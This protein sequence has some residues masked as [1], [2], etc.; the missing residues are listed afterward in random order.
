MFA[1]VCCPCSPVKIG[2]LV[3]PGRV[4]SISVL[5]DALEAMRGLDGDFPGGFIVI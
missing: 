2:W 5:A 3:F 1:V 4:L